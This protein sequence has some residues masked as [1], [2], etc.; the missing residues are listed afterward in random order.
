[1]MDDAT[2]RSKGAA[3]VDFGSPE[4]AAQACNLDGKEAIQGRRLRINPANS[5]PG[6]R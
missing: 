3:F 1:M 6:Q 4:D 5:K 2:G